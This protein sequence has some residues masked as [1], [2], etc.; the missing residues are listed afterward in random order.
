MTDTRIRYDFWEKALLFD[1]S[2]REL[3]QARQARR[4][5]EIGAGANPALDLDFV[6]AHDLE[7][8]LV[9]VDRGELAKA[10]DGYQT[11]VADVT[12]R[13]FALDR[14][15]DFVFSRMVAEHIRNAE[16]FHANVYAM[17]SDG[18]TAF[19]FFPTLYA[20]PFL[21]NRVLPDAITERILLAVDSSR[22]REGKHGKF[23]AYY[24]WCRGPSRRQ[25]SRFERLGYVV[26]EY[27]GFFGHG[28]YGKL[29]PRRIPVNWI[30]AILIEHPVP[31]LT[32]YAHVLLR[33]PRTE[34]K[35]DFGAAASKAV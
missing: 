25:I 5:C 31:H 29:L 10:G 35:V 1:M 11:L 28:Y 17:L 22:T 18:G 27:V 8:V 34:A 9:D 15:F 6:A 7:Y 3:I 26:E 32:S 30:P 2:A 20:W 13:D 21:L 12:R 23:P 16:Q 4:I 19:H 33:R 24:E 14:R